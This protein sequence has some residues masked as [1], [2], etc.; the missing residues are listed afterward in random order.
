MIV[1]GNI[2]QLLT[3]HFYIL[4]PLF[5]I[6]KKYVYYFGLTLL[7]IAVISV[8]TMFLEREVGPSRGILPEKPDM[9]PPQKPKPKPMGE[10]PS[11]GSMRLRIGLMLLFEDFMSSV[12]VIGFNLVNTEEFSF[13]KFTSYEFNLFFVWFTFMRLEIRIKLLNKKMIKIT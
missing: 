1:S 5:F 12:L 4:F 7:V 2:R 11:A 8:I 9:P 13:T 3:G 6:Q 10:I